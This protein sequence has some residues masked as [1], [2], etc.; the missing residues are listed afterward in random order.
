MI[1]FYCIDAVN[2]VVEQWIIAQVGAK[3]GE[4]VHIGKV[5]VVAMLDVHIP[6]HEVHLKSENGRIPP[7][8]R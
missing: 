8:I 2:V 7:D 3:P 1:P 5:D 6:T 4:I